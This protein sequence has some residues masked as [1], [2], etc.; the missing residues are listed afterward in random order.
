M[1][2]GTWEP[3]TMRLFNRFYALCAVAACTILYSAWF[4]TSR[5]YGDIVPAVAEQFQTASSFGQRLVVF[6]DSWSDN[7]TGEEMQGRVWTDW[8]CSMVRWLGFECLGCEIF[9]RGGMVF[10]ETGT[11][12][13]PLV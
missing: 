2:I 10:V 6:G 4:L 13:F 1:I 12:S 5:T 11:D 8:L 7:E 3:E 9:R